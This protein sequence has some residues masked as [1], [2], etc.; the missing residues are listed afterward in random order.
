MEMWGDSSRFVCMKRFNQQKLANAEEQKKNLKVNWR[1]DA[2]PP[3]PTHPSSWTSVGTLN[4]SWSCGE[5]SC[6]GPCLY[7]R[8]VLE[9][10][11]WLHPDLLRCLTQQKDG[12]SC[13]HRQGEGW[14][15]FCLFSPMFQ[16]ELI[17]SVQIQLEFCFGCNKHQTCISSCL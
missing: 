4:M 11:G 7:H 16:G 3:P 17:S 5:C 14:C 1:G 6:R 12:V 2:A 13:L 9:A 15:L 10:Q 8:E